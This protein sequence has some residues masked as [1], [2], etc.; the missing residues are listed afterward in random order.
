MTPPENVT[1]AENRSALFVI[2]GISLVVVLVVGYLLLGH[3][4]EPGAEIGR[5]HV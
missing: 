4:A 3:R 5:A 2:G 1:A